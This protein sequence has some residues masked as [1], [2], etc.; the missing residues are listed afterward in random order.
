MPVNGAD[1]I[2]KAE[3]SLG[4]PYAWGGT[5]LSK[6]VDC[7]GL[8]QAVYAT[9][10]I[11][12][13]RTTYDQI[14]VGVT[15]P[16]AK[17]QAGDLLFFDTEASNKGADHVGIYIGGGKFIQAP[18]TGDVVKISSL[19]D[20]YYMTRLMA[21]KRVPGVTGGGAVADGFASG[22]VGALAAP[23]SKLSP[24][25]LAQ[26]YG[27]SYAFFKSQPELMKLLGS[28]VD[29]QWTPDKFT[30]ELKNTKWWKTNSD[31]ARQAQ[32]QAKTDPATY[33][34]S[35]AAA[36]AQ[37]QDLAVKAGA[38]LGAKQVQQLATNM[39]NYAW[40]DAQ[41]A[42]FL[43]GY[44]DFQSNKVLGGQAG[45]AAAQI[46]QYAYDQG[47]KVSSQTVKNSAAYLVRGISTMQQIQD[48]LKAQAISTYPGFTDQIAAGATMRDIAQPYIQ[49][50]ASELGLPETD[51]D[52]WHPKVQSALN[53]ANAK[54]V[55]AP[56]PLSDFQKTLRTDPAWKA[57]QGAQ[58][59]VLQTGRQ[60][61]QSMGLV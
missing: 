56:V 16:T 59:A 36:A 26:Q 25:E 55:P 27:M 3:K 51:V 52:V 19:S 41:I 11:Q 5:N 10:G 14:N 17:L 18:H 1:I 31:S 54:G 60:V 6:G 15:V 12:L 53:Q 57:T 39:V 23:I 49:M 30:A 46:G 9:F 47:V 48:G 34:A 2:A 50:T 37:A 28:A 22:A 44:V 61:L 20:S 43:G 13:P 33:K 42:S 32:V 40:N 38:I 4:T 35:I 7:S 45:A 21:A 24:T 58:D 8:V 29:S